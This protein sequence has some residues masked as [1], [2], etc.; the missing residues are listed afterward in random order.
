MGRLHVTDPNTKIDYAFCPPTS[1]NHYNISGV[2]PIRRAFYGPDQEQNP[3]GWV[4]DLEHG[5]VVI[6]YSCGQ[7]G[8]SC[9]STAEMDAMRKVFD[10]APSTPGAALCGLP[11]KVIVLRFDSMSTRFAFLTWD[12]AYLTNTFDPNAALVFAQ[13]NQDQTNPEQGVC[14]R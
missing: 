1:G 12:R 14:D 5:F 11:N 3:G 13:Q 2:G 8:K 9:P 6:A 4:H 7:D 10:E